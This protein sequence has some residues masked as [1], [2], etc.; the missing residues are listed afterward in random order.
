[1]KQ[2]FLSDKTANFQVYIYSDNRKII[3]ASALITVYQPNSTTALFTSQAMS[4]GADGLLTYPLTVLHNDIADYNY[5]AVIEYVYNAA[6][7][8]ETCFYDVVRTR[9]A[10]V[11]T[12]DDLINELPQLRKSAW[13]V[14]GTASSGSTTTI[15]DL[16]L[17]IYPDDF[18]TGGMATSLTRDEIREITDFVS[19]TGTITTAAFSGAIAVDKYMLSRAFS[20][21]IQRAFE[22][23]ESM[24]TQAGRRPNS[25]LDSYDLREVHIL[26]AVAEACK[27]LASEQDNLWWGL[28]QPDDK[29]AYAVFKDL[30]LKYDDS[31][32]GVL[33]GGEEQRRI[34]RVTVRG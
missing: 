14:H 12:D 28:W 20:K 9:L 27:G 1:M 16:N 19:S 11:I 6:T 26:L 30:N 18:F 2:Q 21:E 17:K 3:P 5:R 23:L 4:V 24:L 15:V 31:D 10:K 22:K 33:S 8:Y 7:Y 25:V 13:V 32:D 29:R 34:R